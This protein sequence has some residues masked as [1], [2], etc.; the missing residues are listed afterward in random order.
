MGVVLS[1]VLAS[2]SF[3]YIKRASG[4]LTLHL[5]ILHGQ[6]I[7]NLDVLAP[8]PDTANRKIG[9]SLMP[10]MDRILCHF[11]TTYFPVK[12][13][14]ESAVRI[15]CAAVTIKRYILTERPP[16]GFSGS[17]CFAIPCGQMC[18]VL[19]PSYNLDIYLPAFSKEATNTLFKNIKDK[20]F[21]F[22]TSVSTKRIFSRP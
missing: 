19:C 15:L 16:K 3:P 4:V 7:G 8:S 6:Y 2:Y 1:T 18:A 11:A 20:F 9:P 5:A 12:S 14:P 21:G 10:I 22:V 13:W 17:S